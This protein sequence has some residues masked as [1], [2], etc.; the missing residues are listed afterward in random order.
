MDKSNTGLLVV[1]IQGKLARQIHDSS[2]F[3][4]RCA[5]LIKA[6]KALE[7]PVVI[8]EQ[9]PTKLGATVEELRLLLP[10]H[11][12][13]TKYAFNGCEDE[14]VMNAIKHAHADEWLVCGI[15]AHICV[16]QTSVGLQQAGLDVHVVSDCVASRD[17]TNHALALHKY[18]EH[19]L[20]VTGMEMCL[21][22]LMKDC[23]DPAFRT[24]LPLIK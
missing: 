15:E 8:I 7:L 20:S 21:F 2:A 6:A 10:H 14:F 16:Y 23:R 4:S 3:I 12:R 1:D 11:P 9:N 18:R 24:I 13:H 22:E 17:P 19:G 5:T